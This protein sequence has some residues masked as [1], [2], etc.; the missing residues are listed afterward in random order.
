MATFRIL[1]R[2]GDRTV[3]AREGVTLTVGRHPTCEIHID[4]QSV[5]RR[6]CTFEASNGELRVRDLGSAN[7]TFVNEGSVQDAIVRAGDIVRAGSAVLEVRGPD[8]TPRAPAAGVTRHDHGYESVIQRRFEPAAYDWLTSA[9]P[10]TELQV[11]ERAQRHLTTLHRVSELLAEARDI[12]GLSDATLRAIL[13]VTA[14]RRVAGKKT[15]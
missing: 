15:E 8:E 3:E 13:E 5:S 7:G 10:G 2:P 14:R 9:G 12:S 6:H 1:V 11:L 4:D